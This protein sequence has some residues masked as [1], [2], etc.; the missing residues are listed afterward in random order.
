VKKR[1]RDENRLEKCKECLVCEWRSFGSWR[2][3]RI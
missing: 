2:K 3:Q 1:E